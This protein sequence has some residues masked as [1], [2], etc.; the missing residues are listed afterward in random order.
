[1]QPNTVVCLDPTT[2][3]TQVWKIPSGG[4]VVRNMAVAKNG[5]LWL[6]CSGVDRMARV[7]ITTTPAEVAWLPPDARD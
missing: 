1:V 3:A 7:R 5:D 6:A 2:G 4:G